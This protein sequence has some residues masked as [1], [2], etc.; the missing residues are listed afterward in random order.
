MKVS[1]FGSVTT[2]YARAY[3]SNLPDEWVEMLNT[4]AAQKVKTPDVKTVTPNGVVYSCDNDDAIVVLESE[5]NVKYVLYAGS[6]AVATA[7]GDGS[8]LTLLSKAQYA[9]TYA[10]YAYAWNSL[11]Q[12]YDACE[13]VMDCDYT[14]SVP[15]ATVYNLVIVNGNY[16]ED[17]GVELTLYG[18][19]AGFTYVLLKDNE[20]TDITMEGTGKPLTFPAVYEN[21]TYSIAAIYNGCYT[22]MNGAQEVTRYERPTKFDVSVTNYGHFCEGDDDGVIISVEGQQAG[23]VY[24]LYRNGAAYLESYQATTTSSAAI[25]F[26][27]AEAGTYYVVV[28]EPLV[29]N[30]CSIDLDAVVVTQDALP[31]DVT[32]V[33]SSEI[34]CEQ[35]AA[36]IKIYGTESGEGFSVDYTLLRDGN[37]VETVTA[38]TNTIT[39]AAVDVAGTYTVS[40]VKTIELEGDDVYTCNKEFSDA[41]TLTVVSRPISGEQNE[42]VGTETPEGVD[43]CYGTDI[44]IENATAGY[45]Y[46]LYLLDSDGDELTTAIQTFVAT[47]DVSTDRFTDLRYQNNNFVIYVSNGYC[48][49]RL[50]GVVN[51]T[52][53]KYVSTQ[54]V[55]VDNT[56]C[57]GDE[58]NTVMLASSEAGVTYT[59][60]R[61]ADNVDILID[62]MTSQSSSSLIFTQK[63]NTSGTYYIVGVKADSDEACSSIVA[64]FEFNVYPLPV[65]Y[66]LTG[67]EYICAG[68][69]GVVLGLSG[70]EM[71]VTYILYSQDEDGN[72]Q[73]VDTKTGTDN[74]I[75]FA[76]V[77]AGTYVASARNEV[78]GCTSSMMGTKV[79]VEAE[80]IET[81]T[82]ATSLVACQGSVDYELAAD[83]MTEGVTYYLM[84]GS[85]SPEY[86]APLT[87]I[88]ADGASNLV[89]TFATDGTYTIWAS[90]GDYACL[91]QMDG[92]IVVESVEFTAHY[93]SSNENENCEGAAME[94]Y[95]DGS[96]LGVTY[97]LNGIDDSQQ[98]GNGGQLTWTVDGSGVVLYEVY[99]VD[100]R[101]CPMLIDDIK[102]D[103]DNVA[104]PVATL[105]LYVDGVLVEA[106][107][108]EII[109]ICSNSTMTLVASIE[110]VTPSSYT[111][112]NNNSQTLS[113]GANPVIVIDPMTLN[114]DDG[115]ANITLDITT[116]NGCSYSSLVGITLSRREIEV[117]D[118]STEISWCGSISF[119][120]YDLQDG[121]TYYVMEGTESPLTANALTKMTAE[122]DE[123]GTLV[124]NLS[125]NFTSAGIY[126]LWASFDDY[127]C[128]TQM[129]GIIV[130]QKVNF[131]HYKA[132]SNETE[133]CSPTVTI[134]LQGSDEDVWYY[135]QTTG[136]TS[137]SE[138][139]TGDAIEFSTT[140][141]DGSSRTFNVIATS[142]GCSEVITTITVN[143]GSYVQPE[144]TMALYLEGV[145][146]NISSVDTLEVCSN[147]NVT[148]F[149]SVEGATVTDYTF[150]LNGE[151]LRTSTSPF[152]IPYIA[153]KTGV[154]TYSLGVE[155]KTGCV[156]DSLTSLTIKISDSEDLDG[157]LVAAGGEYEYCSGEV[158]IK[159]CFLDAEAGNIYRLYR[160]GDIPEL[161]EIEEI[162]KYSSL[163][164]KDTLWFESW[165][166]VD[167]TGADYAQAGTYFVEIEN[168]DDGCVW[169][170]TSVVVTENALPVNDLNRAY[171]AMVN[172]DIN[173]EYVVNEETI[174]EAF[175]LLDAGMV[176]LENAMLDIRYELY[177]ADKD[178]I[179]QTLY[180]NEEG[181]T[182]Y[183]GPVVSEST[184]SITGA[185]DGWG[186]GLY[187]I[188]ATDLETGCTVEIGSIEFVEEE[189]TAYDIYLYL[190][191]DQSLVRQQ[192]APT[193]PNKGNHKYIDWST[194]ID[195]VYL[196]D[197]ESSDDGLPTL[198]ESGVDGYEEGSGYT[199]M[200][201]SANIVFEIVPTYK[202]T[203][204]ADTTW[205][206]SYVTGCDSVYFDS[207]YNYYEVIYDADG[208]PTDTVAAAGDCDT[209]IREVVD[210]YS[211]FSVGTALSTEEVELYGNYGFYEYDDA[212]IYSSS[213][214]SGLFVY[215]KRPSFYGTETINYR[216]YNNKL[217]NVRYSNTATITVL[218]G[219]EAVGDSTSVFLIPNAFSPNGDGYN[220]EFRIILPTEYEEYS[221]SS[222]EVFN[223]WGT[224]VYKSSGNQYG[225][226]C[227]W[228]DGTS[229]TS[230]MLTVG[231]KLPSGTYFYVYKITFING[232]QATKSTKKMNGYIELR[233]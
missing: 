48:V 86:A 123:N 107:E 85:D 220:D 112:T 122:F 141:L 212:A 186:V 144:A 8:D 6:V 81:I 217:K 76:M 210:R 7:I 62:Q 202:T 36:T 139:G 195:V 188:I 182:L 103:Y 198:K 231:E 170:T 197:T 134:T 35:E 161:M 37:V 115:Y 196:P 176:I 20:A 166:V 77:E 88:V 34:I 78:S 54:T 23:K 75:T 58:G 32:I 131:N 157:R 92:M 82:V 163:S 126:T 53:D 194:S 227:D 22:S 14:V 41:V 228:W 46:I 132:T 66:Q 65:S 208:L 69:S 29:D 165:T 117:F 199:T 87:Q 181:Q 84:S 180:A 25:E 230:N 108:E 214:K 169:R 60:Y 83:L 2:Y 18:S 104:V 213:S 183:F 175:G 72:L 93:L 204:V 207:Y 222:L 226:D 136:W 179:L 177:N 5:D 94:L 200:E 4:V 19:D 17:D 64:N 91:T 189:L 138:L 154:L 201:S 215:S 223:R 171:Y 209:C 225:K 96:E 63:I 119:L 149:A 39:F 28:T 203:T 100:Q 191:K 114:L 178:A 12:D 27:V 99:A 98:N 71:D 216:I 43:D 59:L 145:E 40:A 42:V 38:T 44:Y 47:G 11:T 151:T 206:G 109:S 21:G 51:I 121:V 155:T 74:A 190:N 173:G 67:S 130:V 167:G 118:V 147:A 142:E 73:I 68:E 26:Q 164:V 55:I 128:L 105:S 211:Y 49:D 24:T 56:M 205:Y 218:C 97:Y 172:E 50:S 10:V 140:Y 174:S 156:F 162:S 13:T 80:E 137:N 129:D 101:G 133:V 30:G 160:D 120:D 110:N 153:D 90:F 168:L 33:I 148:I 184:D 106:E 232:Q 159:L 52:S 16:C 9:G 233:R 113:S 224:L 57:Q 70:S 193:L 221:E 1:S 89:Y 116:K 102:V 192:I 219:N 45:Q 124:D 31:Q 150:S 135:L 152:I 146:Q 61:S 95:L 125:V 185:V 127:A 3:Y 187:T 15:E 158:G 79:V 111:F 143:Y 229:R